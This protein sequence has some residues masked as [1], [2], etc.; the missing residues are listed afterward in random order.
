MI[1]GMAYYVAYRPNGTSWQMDGLTIRLKQTSQLVL[2]NPT[3]SNN[4]WTVC[5]QQNTLITTTGWYP[6]FFTTPF[7]YNG[8]LAAKNLLV[9]VS[10][11]G[12]SNPADG[13][14][15]WSIEPTAGPRSLYFGCDDCVCGGPTPLTW[16]T[17]SDPTWGSPFAIPVVP[18]A[19]FF[20]GGGPGHRGL[21]PGRLDLHGHH[22]GG[23][24]RNVAG[25]RH[26]LYA[27][28]LRPD[29]RLLPAERKLHGHPAGGLHG[30]LAGRLHDLHAEPVRPD[31][32]LLPDEW[33][34]HG[35]HAV[36]LHGNLAGRRHDLHTESLPDSGGVLLFQRNVHSVYRFGLYKLGRHILRRRHDMQSEPLP[37]ARRMLLQG[38]HMHGQA[39][40]RLHGG[41]GWDLAGPEYD[42]YAKP[43][44][45]AT[46]GLL[47]P[48]R[49]LRGADAGG[50]RTGGR[51]RLEHR[52]AVQPQPP[53]PLCEPQQGPRL[54]ASDAVAW[55]R[56]GWSVAKS[57]DTIAVGS[58]YDDNATGADAGAVYVYVL[59]GGV[60]SEQAKVMPTGGT[61]YMYFGGSVALDG[62]T[63]LAG[64]YYAN[65]LVTQTGAAYVFTRTGTTWTQ[66]AK[67]TASD[68]A[69]SDLFG[70]SVALKGGY[71]VVGAY[72]ANGGATGSGAAYVY[73]RS[74]TTWAQ[75][76]K[77]LPS[78]PVSGGY[79]G[80]SVAFSGNTVIAG[81][82][83]ANG[84][85]SYSGAAYVFTRSGTTWTQ[86][87]K[88]TAAD[89]VAG[90]GFGV[91]VALDADTSLIGALWKNSSMGAAYVFTRS[92]TSWTQQAKLTA[93]DGVK[94]DYFGHAVAVAADTALIGSPYDSNERGLNA[95]SAYDFS[96][97]GSSWLQRAKLVPTDAVAGDRFGAS[98][99]L[100]GS[101]AVM[102]EYGNT[103]AYGARDAA[104]VFDLN[105]PG[106][107]CFHDGHCE[108]LLSAAC[109][110]AGG[111]AWTMGAPCVPNLCP[112]P[113]GACC[114]DGGNCEQWFQE[115][116]QQAGG[117]SWTMD[118]PCD[119]NPCP[120]PGA[121]CFHDGYC[122][123]MLQAACQQ[124]GGAEWI[125]DALCDPN[126]CPQPLG[127]CCFWFGNCEQLQ[128]AACEQAG[129]M[130]WA[131]DAPCDPNPCPQPMGACCFNDGH[132]EQ[133]TYAVCLQAGGTSWIIDMPCDPN[134]CPQPGACCFHDGHCQQLTEASCTQAGGTGWIMGLSCEPNPCPQPLGACCFHNGFCERLL[135]AAC[136]QAGGTG[137]TMD[138]LCFPNPCP[139]PMGACCFHDGHCEQLLPSACMQAGGSTWI[140]DAPCDPNP[141]PQPC[142]LLG[143]VNQDDVVNGLDIGG[144]IRAKLGEPPLPGEEPSCADFGTGTLEGDVEAFVCKLL[145]N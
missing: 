143:D 43:L 133:L 71:A 102:G 86:E 54:T 5:Y 48:R 103:E 137:W 79:F 41:L 63:L 142:T 11:D 58:P 132:C 130:S 122:M 64:A 141:C 44:L 115:V 6:F 129:G 117:I 145:A 26:N 73:I 51:D 94:N 81:A 62:D 124:A 2:S 72:Y 28:P 59:S 15:V 10:F 7:N 136:T 109:T 65:G 27:Q 95:G 138:A 34:L 18:R 108:E 19:Q 88:L 32:R 116:C 99:A 14:A 16:T 52:S 30:N 78:D 119:P 120:Q 83:A 114:L 96:R 97:S 45:A 55:D 112:Q 66:Q 47:F 23:L 125:A 126:P 144:F 17:C 1:T 56:F 39:S 105:C 61:A 20:F 35:H 110:Q 9:D 49:A 22:A 106:A 4:G 77:L 121:C 12:N 67:L 128:Q 68:G 100:D 37:A 113:L 75:Q 134:P 21:L 82:Y 50:L 76:A 3:F 127:A 40:V 24:H 89:A 90:D 84:P 98:L 25:G 91:A 107:C 92:G 13:Y 80:R 93:A 36:C 31:R 42:L 70:F 101:T 111:T 104:Y 118:A 135:Q 53:C 85:V 46:R 131:M 33:K 29:R 123:R 87:A 69:I 60:W 8:L 57:G 74:G 140:M 139:L 38:W